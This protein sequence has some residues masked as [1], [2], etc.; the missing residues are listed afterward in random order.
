MS[1]PSTAAVNLSNG[2]PPVAALSVPRPSQPAAFA[3]AIN[4]ARPGSSISPSGVATGTYQSKVV[5]HT[6]DVPSR[7]TGASGL[8]GGPKVWKSAEHGGSHPH[9][10]HEFISSITLGRPPEVGPVTAAEWTAAGICAHESAINYGERISV[11]QYR[12]R[13]Y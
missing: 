11:P 9:L 10:V 3:R 4:W 13:S 6:V 1:R 5:A 8:P 7:E 2:R 12:T